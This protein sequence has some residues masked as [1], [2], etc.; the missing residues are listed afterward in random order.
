LLVKG[1]A[2]HVQALGAYL[3]R[4][5]RKG[6]PR[7]FGSLGGMRQWIESIF[8]TLK[9]QLGLEHHGGRNLQGVFVRVAQRLLALAASVRFNWQHGVPNKRSLLAFDHEPTTNPTESII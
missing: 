6:K 4:P 2:R 8:D 3:A 5:D 9:D 7:R 1:S